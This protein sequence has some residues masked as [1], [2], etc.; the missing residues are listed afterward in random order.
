M[1]KLPSSSLALALATALA[2]APA[3]TL[4]QPVKIVNGRAQVIETLKP[5][6]ASK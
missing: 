4:A 6:W 5:A 2:A 1:Y 3:A